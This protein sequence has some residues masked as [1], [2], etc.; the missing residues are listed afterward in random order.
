MIQKNLIKG[1]YE[2][3]K[4]HEN[5]NPNFGTPTWESRKI[6]HLDV[7][8]M[9]SHKIYYKEGSGVSSQRL[10][11]ASCVKFVF[12]VVLLNLLHHLCSTCIN[13]PLFLVV[14]FDFILNSCLWVRPSFIPKLHHAFLP[15]KC[16]KLRNVPHFI[17]FDY[18]ILGP[19]FRSLK[20]F[21]GTSITTCITKYENHPCYTMILTILLFY[22]LILYLCIIIN[23]VTTRVL[24]QFV[25]FSFASFWN[26]NL[27]CCEY[28]RCL[29]C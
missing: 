18:F 6:Y 14:Q 29:T 12:E 25:S 23:V 19:T 7:T 28:E 4:F 1:I 8:L 27:P 21:G 17:F 2:C 5:K 15:L 22:P 26:H 16:C 13:Y 3:P 10:R 11:V 24:L 9:E 20:K